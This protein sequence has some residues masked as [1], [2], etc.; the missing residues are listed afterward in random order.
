MRCVSHDWIPMRDILLAAII[1]GSLPL[2]LARPWVG[3]VMWNWI[4]FMNPHR[5][6]WGFMYDLPIAA[7][8]GGTAL[9]AWVLSKE[10]RTIPWDTI[11]ILMVVYL[12]WSTLTTLFAV[13][14]DDAWLKWKQFFKVILMIVVALSLIKK[15]IHFRAFVWTAVA[16]IGF[17]SFKGGIFTVLHGGNFTVWGPPGTNISDNNGLALATLMIIPL[18]IYLAQTTDKKWVRIGLYIATLFSF[19]SVVGSYSRGAFLGMAAIAVILWLR[20]NKKFML[21]VIMVVVVGVSIQFVPGKY[22]DRIDTI[23]NYEQDA[24]ALGRLAV[25]G[26]A[27]RIANSR[28]IV[29]GGYQVFYHPP[30]YERLSPDIIQRAVHSVYFEVLGE[31]GYVGLILF[32]ALGITALATTSRIKKLC[33]NRP[34]FEDEYKFANMIFISLVA[35]AV[36]G[37][38][39]NMG[40]YDLYYTLLAFIVLQYQLVKVKLA[41]ESNAVEPKESALETRGPALPQRA[42]AVRRSFLRSA[43]D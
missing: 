16:S 32:L 19:I 38:F 43:T 22:F 35:Y 27:I 23:Q 41:N 33:R 29:G 7:I 40:T 1:F 37:A 9:V 42:P 14:P 10:D 31:H 34:G 28:P 13:N 8:I 39:L 15:E 20:S 24:S 5:L 36:S 3:I 18:M 30:T 25:W 6:S 21:N 26:H 2:I 4:S 17:F 12:A 11:A